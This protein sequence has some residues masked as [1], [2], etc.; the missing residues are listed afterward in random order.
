MSNPLSY[1]L[2][3]AIKGIAWSAAVIAVVRGWEWDVPNT[4]RHLRQDGNRNQ[5]VWLA[6]T[7]AYAAVSAD[8]ALE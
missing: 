5:N 4:Q 8:S 2:K 1:I 7:C 6:V 3:N